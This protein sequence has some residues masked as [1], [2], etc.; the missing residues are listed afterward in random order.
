MKT[1]IT[2]TRPLTVKQEQYAREK[3]GLRSSVRWNI[4][5]GTETK[6]RVD[7][8]AQSSYIRGRWKTTRY[9]SHIA[10]VANYS[11]VAKNRLSVV[12]YTTC[13]LTGRVEKRR[14]KVPAGYRIDQD[15]LGIRI[16]RDADG[17]DYHPD[18]Y[19]R[20]LPI[21]AW[22]ERMAFLDAQRDAEDK[23]KAE[24]SAL[25]QRIASDANTTRVTLQDSRRVGN[26]VHG[27]LAFASRL[28]YNANDVNG[29]NVPGIRANVL[30]RTGDE[31]AKRAVRAAW[32]RETLVCI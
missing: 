6:I 1:N 4:D 32:E 14:E 10:T 15:S 12:H 9:A 13:P 17:R 8:N 7:Q 11:E 20:N 28:G 27:S 26:C 30:L 5:P 21:S 2:Y 25:W 23:R 16:V 31:R 22:V 29:L 24:D 3:L 19:E 18:S